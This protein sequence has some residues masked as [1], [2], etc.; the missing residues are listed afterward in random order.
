MCCVGCSPVAAWSVTQQP[1]SLTS[2]AAEEPNDDGTRQELLFDRRESEGEQTILIEREAT[3]MLTL[4]YVAVVGLIMV[5]AGCATVPPAKPIATFKE[6][7][8]TWEGQYVLPSGELGPRWEQEI[9]EDGQMRF[10]RFELPVEGTRQLQ[11]R[12]GRVVYDDSMF[13][14]GV[15]T[16][17]E[18]EGRRILKDV[19]IQKR[20]GAVFTGEFT[21]KQ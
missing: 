5:L 1:R 6:I 19:A 18:V 8:G 10:K 15:L 14:S 7:A 20:N 2:A 12:D 13:W 16:L 9:R 11:L 4:R 21:L 17:H 3:T